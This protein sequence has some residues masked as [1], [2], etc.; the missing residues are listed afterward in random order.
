MTLA[1]PELLRKVLLPYALRRAALGGL[2][3]GTGFLPKK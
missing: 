2:R 3:R 1:V